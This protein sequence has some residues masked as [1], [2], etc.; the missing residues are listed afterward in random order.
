MSSESSR[1]PSNRWF[2][3]AIGGTLLVVAVSI[4]TGFVWLPVAERDSPFRSVWDAICSSAGLIRRSPIIEVS[5]PNYKTSNVVVSPE[6]LPAASAESIGRGGTLALRCTMCHGP[7][8]V[9]DAKTPNLAGQYAPAIYKQLR[10]FRSGARTSPVMSPLVQNLSDQEMRDLAAFYGYLPR[11]QAYHPDN[12]LTPQ[13]VIHGA[14]MRNIP[15]CAACHGTIGYKVG[16]E[17][18]DGESPTYLRS[19]LEA[20]ASGARHND[21]SEQMRNVARGMTPAEIEQA[22]VYFAGQPPTSPALRR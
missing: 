8:G 11:L 14:P 19:E 6:M 16:T 1:A 5:K 15:P 17:W 13:I 22:A 4:V 12:E 7:R 10:D 3:T 2:A 9:S 21:I 18:L 20:F